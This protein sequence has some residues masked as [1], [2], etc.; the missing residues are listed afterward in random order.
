MNTST[1][2]NV[3]NFFVISYQ[4]LNNAQSSKTHLSSQNLKNT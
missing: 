2:K 1:R 3:Q 4:E